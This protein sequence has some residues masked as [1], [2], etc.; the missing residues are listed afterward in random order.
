M[1]LKTFFARRVRP[2]RLYAALLAAIP[3]LLILFSPT[4]NIGFINDDFMEIGARHFDALDSLPTENYGLWA[5]RYVL[6]ALVDPVS[7]WEIFRP[8][9]QVVFWN[10]Y[11]MFHLDPL[12][13]RLSNLV[14]YLAACLIVGLLAWRLTR[15]RSAAA[16]S[17]LLF[18]LYPVHFGPVAAIS[19]LGHLL[20]G[21]FVGLCVLLYVV[22]PTRSTTIGAWLACLFAIGSKE[23]ALVTPVL[24]LLYELVYRRESILR[25]PRAF[26]PRQLPFWLIA[27][28]SLVLR[29][30]IFGGH[31]SDVPYT[32][33]TISFSFIIEQYIV[34]GLQPFLSDINLWQSAL[35]IGLL[36]LLLV[37]YRK[38]REVVFGLLWIPVALVITIPF[39]PQGRY[40]ITP[41]SGIAIA[42][43]SI[44]SQPLNVKMAWTRWA[45]VGLAGLVLV[46]F[47]LG[48]DTRTNQY[49]NLGAATQKVLRS[50][51]TLHPQF[52]KRAEIFIT[53]LPAIERGRVLIDPRLQYA[54][55]MAYGDRSL[56]ANSVDAFPAKLDAPDRAFFFEYD[57]KLT[58][59]A[60]LVQQISNHRTCGAPDNAIV[61]NF[62]KDADGWEAWN[63]IDAFAANEGLLEFQ[64]TGNDPFM[65]SPYLQVKARQLDHIEI[66]LRAQAT[67][68]TLHAKLYW[69]T[70]EMDDFSPDLVA[71]FEVTADN[72]LHSYT[73]TPPLAGKADLVRLRLDPADAPANVAIQKIALYCR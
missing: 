64:T 41:S 42:F 21:L 26:V 39:I 63:Q 22:P 25:E 73:I 13:Y 2:L 49:H 1:N 67:D 35:F 37:L 11:V 71:P 59:R 5:Q 28:G 10:N 68:P 12:G 56:Q 51:Q 15:R 20:A 61:W 17:L 16:M 30:I 50:I 65:A 8:T 60:D 14:L 48:A 18:A 54:L 47:E 46:G 62:E 3:V 31:L 69:Q 53:G 34:L 55:Q 9:R 27:G 32:V 24:L 58:E 40:L 29:W 52:P 43:G 4:F 57:R 45:A 7:G 66:T 44:L 70:S 6:R 72:T 23:T 38:R 33:G 19:S 36:V